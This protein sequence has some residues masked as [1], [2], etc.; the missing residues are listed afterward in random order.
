MLPN[1]V[2]L[3]YN[4]IIVFKYIIIITVF[5]INVVCKSSS[6]L[7]LKSLAIATDTAHCYVSILGETLN[8]QILSF[9]LSEATR[10]GQISLL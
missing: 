8:M 7:G 6:Y 4:I 5:S 10:Y 3:I 9:Q 2:M 1:S